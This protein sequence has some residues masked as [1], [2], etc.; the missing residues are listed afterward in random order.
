MEEDRKNVESGRIREMEIH[1]HIDPLFCRTKRNKGATE[2]NL[3][4]EQHPFLKSI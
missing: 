4:T 2:I 1:S 3:T